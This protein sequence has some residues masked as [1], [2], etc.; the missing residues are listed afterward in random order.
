[1]STKVIKPRELSSPPPQ[2]VGAL[3]LDTYSTTEYPP[4]R[5]AVLAALA[6]SV[7]SR[8]V[9][10]HLSKLLPD[11]HPARGRF[12]Y[13]AYGKLLSETLAERL[14]QLSSPLRSSYLKTLRCCE[15]LEVA[16]PT[17]D[18][19]TGEYSNTVRARSKF[20]KQR[21]CI[22]C[23]RNSIGKGLYQYGDTVLGWPSP[24]FVT[25]TIRNVSAEQ[26][27]SAVRGMVATLRRICQSKEG[28]AWKIRGVRKIE[29]TFNA[30]RCD[31]HPHLHCIVD[32]FEGGEWL[33]DA[34]LKRYPN[35]ATFS[36]QDVRPVDVSK[37]LKS[38][39][40]LFK[41]YNKLAVKYKVETAGHVSAKYDSERGAF[42]AEVDE[43]RGMKLA[44]IQ[45]VD[46]AAL[47]TMFVAMRRVRAT[48]PIGAVRARK[49]KVKPTWTEALNEE[50]VTYWWAKS[51]ANWIDPL[52]GRRLAKRMKKPENGGKKGGT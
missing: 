18:E 41:Y 11:E 22:V 45:T 32:T 8:E 49:D 47:D 37:G 26:L 51:V 21:W 1:M 24:T 29:C 17:I 20:C 19:A 7:R 34:W 3:L 28:R 38:V 44:E 23:N 48:Q 42:V 13:R 6:A 36:A 46:I 50:A 12:W 40:E 16:R 25:L 4:D 5:A 27:S 31:Y 10:R 43:E 30:E 9:K 2:G 52:S 14:A 35:E 33:R 39:A 15:H